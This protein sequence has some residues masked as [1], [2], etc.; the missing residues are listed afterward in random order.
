MLVETWILHFVKT[1]HVHQLWLFY[2]G[3]ICYSRLFIKK[4]NWKILLININTI[5]KNYLFMVIKHTSNL[6]QFFLHS[7]IIKQSAHCKCCFNALI[8]WSQH[9]EGQML[10]GLMIFLQNPGILQKHTSPKEHHIFL[11]GG[12]WVGVCGVRGRGLRQWSPSQLN[13][14][15]H[16][17]LAPENGETRFT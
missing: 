13:N 11:L 10:T 3:W 17:N 7:F 16:K 15:H 5:T 1:L 14:R 6:C 2:R 9:R 12:C 4:Q 8:H